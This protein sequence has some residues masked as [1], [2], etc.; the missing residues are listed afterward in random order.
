M[1][2]VY[3]GR[4]FQTE[5]SSSPV[6]RRLS[7]T[8]FLL[9]RFSHVS[10][11]AYTCSTHVCLPIHTPCDDDKVACLTTVRPSDSCK[12][13]PLAFRARAATLSTHITAPTTAR[14]SPWPTTSSATCRGM[15]SRRR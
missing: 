10:T 4:M 6:T 2:Q 8:V 11:Y 5:N 15:S 1:S 3:I 13:R 9:L 7:L 14:L 12:R